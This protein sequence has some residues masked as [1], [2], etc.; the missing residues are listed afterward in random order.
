M[1]LKNLTIQKLGNQTYTTLLSNVGWA[2][3]GKHYWE[4][5]IDKFQNEDDVFIG[6]AYKNIDITS[7]PTHSKF[8]GIIPLYAKR[9]SPLDV[10]NLINYGSVVKAGDTIGMLVQ[11]ANKKANLTFYRNGISFGIAYQGISG[12]LYPAI[13]L[14]GSSN[15]VVEISYDPQASMPF[16]N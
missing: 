15:N 1:K 12:V 10:G 16:I 3:S 5:K 14:F 2:E 4:V 11:F 8:W 6:V 9:F 13:T 7:C